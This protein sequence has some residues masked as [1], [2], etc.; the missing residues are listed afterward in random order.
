MPKHLAA[1]QLPR[2]KHP[3]PNPRAASG[4][5][6]AA[7]FHPAN[8]QTEASAKF[9]VPFL[10]KA[11][12]FVTETLVH[13]TRA[14]RRLPRLTPFC[15]PRPALSSARYTLPPS[16]ASRAPALHAMGQLLWLT[17]PLNNRFENLPCAMRRSLHAP[18]FLRNALS[19]VCYAL[20]LPRSTRPAP[21]GVRD[22]FR[23]PAY[24]PRAIQFPS[25]L[26]PFCAPRPALSAPVTPYP[27]STFRR[28][29]QRPPHYTNRY[30]SL[31][32][33]MLPA[34]YHDMSKD[35][36]RLTCRPSLHAAPRS[37]KRAMQGAVFIRQ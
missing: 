5:L 32:I 13:T 15:A 2:T 28:A 11:R 6:P 12:L 37:K 31:P 35:R 17:P 7:A 21:C 16:C 24:A 27:P 8:P 34:A 26:T 29:I 3:F 20:R 25:R 30:P 22:G 9:L 33:P 36:A 18:A 19:S 4:W 1:I 23:F 10:K 14:I